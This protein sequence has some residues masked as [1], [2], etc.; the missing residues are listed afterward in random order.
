MP[1]SGGVARHRRHHRGTRRL[2]EHDARATAS[3]DPQRRR[4]HRRG[5]EMEEAVPAD[6]RPGVV[7]RW[8]H[9]HR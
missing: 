5:G 8:E 1:G 2:A 4:I 3:G 6:G 7:A 9:L